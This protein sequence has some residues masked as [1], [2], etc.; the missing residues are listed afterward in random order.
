VP[1]THCQ[2]ARLGREI[3][4]AVWLALRL[5]LPFALILALSGTA[6]SSE[7]LI[8]VGDLAQ[9]RGVRDNQLFGLGL[10]IGLNGTGDQSQQTRKTIANVLLRL[11]INVD[12]GDLSSKNVALVMVTADLPPFSGPGS[13]IDITVSSIGDATSLFGGT[14]VQTPLEGADKN[15]YAVA[16]GAVSVGGF[17]VDGSAATVRKNH[18]TV[19]R[20]QGGAT[21]EANV[22]MVMLNDRGELTLQLSDP[23]FTTAARIADEIRKVLGLETSAFD[24]ATVHLR[25]P[26][27]SR[28]GL[29]LP[30]LVSRILQVTVA[31][32]QRARV[33]INER[34]GTIVAGNSIIITSVAIAHGDLKITIAES[35]EVA[36]PLP[37]SD[38][39]KTVVVPR[40]DVQVTEESSPVVTL[41]RGV[42][43]AEMAKS[44][45]SLGVSPR[46]LSDIFQALKKAGA[47]HADLEFM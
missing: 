40:T 9:I 32:E 38:T 45:N 35:P 2:T 15:V 30:R 18:P 29:E 41:E 24:A 26:A 25:I 3:R 22:P 23:G 12:P 14:L 46:D 21:I 31:P 1:K 13:R 44:L 19:G 34:T 7:D 39:G 36:Q 10:V 37:F 16:Q 17:Q 4:R 6:Q 20:I 42:T 8:P 11:H 33:V 47:L 43:A 27:E 5:A 28:G